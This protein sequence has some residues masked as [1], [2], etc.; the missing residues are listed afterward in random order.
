MEGRIFGKGD[1]MGGW[2]RGG[3][4]LVHACDC[5]GAISDRDGVV[6]KVGHIYI[7]H[8]QY[9]DMFPGITIFRCEGSDCGIHG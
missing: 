5:T 2:F 8:T 1:T 9:S 6:E 7:R 4:E 3:L